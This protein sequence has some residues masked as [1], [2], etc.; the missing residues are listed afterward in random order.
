MRVLPLESYRKIGFGHDVFTNS[1]WLG[2]DELNFQSLR[3]YHHQK[4]LDGKLPMNH[5]LRFKTIWM[6]TWFEN[7]VLQLKWDKI[8]L[9][10]KTVVDDDAL[11]IDDL[12]IEVFKF[13]EVDNLDDERG[14]TRRMG[15][16]WRTWAIVIVII[17][18]IAVII[19]TVTLVRIM[20]RRPLHPSYSPLAA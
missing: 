6:N 17:V 9:V 10:S 15:M 13:K 11:A 3:L 19:L 8:Y 5:Q 7:S 1:T 4:E 12:K 16:S 14:E 18:V 20:R 2:V